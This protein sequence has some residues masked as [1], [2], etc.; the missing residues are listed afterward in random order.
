ML[1][2]AVVLLYTKAIQVSL[3]TLNALAFFSQIM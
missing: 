1:G 3:I 2:A